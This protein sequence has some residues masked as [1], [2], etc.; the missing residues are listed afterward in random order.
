VEDFKEGTEVK[1]EL[2]QCDVMVGCEGKGVK[3]GRRICP[4][5]VISKLTTSL[6]RGIGTIYS[7]PFSLFPDVKCTCR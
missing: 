2:T 7:I 4:Y 5:S 1:F 6:E 3:E